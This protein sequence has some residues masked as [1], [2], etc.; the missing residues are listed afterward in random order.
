MIHSLLSKNAYSKHADDHY[1][2]LR[3][4][5]QYYSIIQFHMPRNKS[6][7]GEE[8]MAIVIIEAHLPEGIHSIKIQHKIS[9]KEFWEMWTDWRDT[10]AEL[11]M[12]RVENEIFIQKL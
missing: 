8:P 1:R 7:W 10:D 12:E 5:N 4:N 3:I 2:M 11:I 6:V 9:R